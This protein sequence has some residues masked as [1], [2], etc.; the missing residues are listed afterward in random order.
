M[1]AAPYDSLRNGWATVKFDS[2]FAYLAMIAGRHGC[3]GC[4]LLTRQCPPLAPPLSEWR[5][6]RN[7]YALAKN[8]FLPLALKVD[9]K[10]ALPRRALIVNY[11][12]GLTFLLQMLSGTRSSASSAF[13]AH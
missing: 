9:A 3:T 8:N 13:S 6:T 4:W 1:V 10:W 11:V 2:P 5:R 7:V 12:T